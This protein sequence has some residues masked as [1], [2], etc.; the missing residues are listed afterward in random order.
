MGHCQSVTK[1]TQDGRLYHLLL[2][3][4]QYRIVLDLSTSLWSMVA[5][6]TLHNMVCGF[7]NFSK[8]KSTP[9]IATVTIGEN[10]VVQ[11]H[12]AW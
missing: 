9:A 6:F 11:A 3:F 1:K 10:V 7:S 5:S 8:S 4:V 2:S 12:P